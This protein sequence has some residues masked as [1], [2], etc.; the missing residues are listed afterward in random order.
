MKKQHKEYLT[1]RECEEEFDPTHPDH[2]NRVYHNMCGECSAD[3]R[4]VQ[5]KKAF[6]GFNK[7]GDWE[8]IEIVSAKH[9]DKYKRLEAIYGEDESSSV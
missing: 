2:K 6:T 8:G 5:T 4:D 9:F 1:C 3:V 7:D